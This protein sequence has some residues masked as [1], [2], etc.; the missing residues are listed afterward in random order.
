M[1]T[2]HNDE[3]EISNEFRR[4]KDTQHVKNSKRGDQ[5]S[6]AGIIGLIRN[7]LIWSDNQISYS[8]YNF[9]PIKRNRTLHFMKI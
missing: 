1:E 5:D 3:L 2:H 8:G 7:D 9:R 6:Y 4:F